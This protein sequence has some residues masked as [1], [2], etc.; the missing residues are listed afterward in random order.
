MV[1]SKGEHAI[2]RK[3]ETIDTVTQQELVPDWL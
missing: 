3:A 1:S 2:I